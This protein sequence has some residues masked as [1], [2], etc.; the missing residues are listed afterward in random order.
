M[1]SQRNNPYCDL[2]QLVYCKY[3][4]FYELFKI[5]QV[6]FFILRYF[7]IFEINK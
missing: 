3:K 2:L 6:L 4:I 1:F 7:S 5:L